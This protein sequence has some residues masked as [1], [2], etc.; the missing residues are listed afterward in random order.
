ML[1]IFLVLRLNE[2]VF[3]FI[4]LG[5]RAH[6]CFCKGTSFIYKHILDKVILAK[7][8]CNFQCKRSFLISERYMKLSYSLMDCRFFVF[9]SWLAL[10]QHNILYPKQ[11]QMIVLF[12]LNERTDITW[13]L[14][15]TQTV[16]NLFE[17][18]FRTIFQKNYNVTKTFFQTIIFLLL[19]HT[20]IFF[21]SKVSKHDQHFVIKPKRIYHCNNHGGNN[22]FLT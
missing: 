21:T 5:L 11:P 6:I 14:C 1:L 12:W 3:S 20:L 19:F 2:G 8:G 22:I 10:I 16:L 9:S 15:A 13:S 18:V 4:F 7:N 17:R